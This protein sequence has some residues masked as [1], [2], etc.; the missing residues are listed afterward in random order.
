MTKDEAL[1]LLKQYNAW[2]RDKND[3][4]QHEMPNPTL[5]GLAI[6]HAIKALEQLEQKP[7]AWMHRHAGE[8]TEF[9][10]FQSCQFCEPLYT[11]P[12]QSCDKVSQLEQE[13]KEK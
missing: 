7:V 2:R 11:H 13:L 8:I 10:D 1:I 6:D 9:N 4:N 12:S 5:L 3:I